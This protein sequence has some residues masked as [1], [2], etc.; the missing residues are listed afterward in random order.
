MTM[1]FKSALI[2]LCGVGLGAGSTYFILKKKYDEQMNEESENLKAY[3]EDKYRVEDNEEPEETDISEVEFKIEDA[4]METVAVM[5]GE[6]EPNYDEIVNKLNYNQYSTKVPS[7]IDGE[8]QP[9][10]KPYV[11]DM[12]DYNTDQSY[13]KKIVSFFE[14][15]EVCM[16]NDTK[17]IIENVAKDIGIDNIELINTEGNE[18]IYVRNERLGIDY[19]IVAEPGSYEDYIAVGS[20]E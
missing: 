6:P 5:P 10:K 15:D 14:E 9:S 11:I 8:V 17:E 20:D 18:E 3:Y 2:F 1:D 13:I 4:T 12:D 16:D 19:N 7:P